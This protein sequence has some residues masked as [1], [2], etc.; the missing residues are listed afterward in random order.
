MGGYDWSSNMN[1]TSVNTWNQSG[2][3]NWTVGSSPAG[4]YKTYDTFTFLKVYNAGHMGII[5][6]LY[7]DY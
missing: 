6:L 4:E 3:H 7:Y 2:W 5:I 1:W